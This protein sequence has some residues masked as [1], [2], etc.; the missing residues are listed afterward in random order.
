M[1]FDIMP[2]WELKKQIKYHKNKNFYFILVIILKSIYAN[3]NYINHK[4]KYLPG[5]I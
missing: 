1:E 5:I 3:L 2:N 4:T